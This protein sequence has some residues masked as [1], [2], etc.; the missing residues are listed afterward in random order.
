VIAVTLALCSGGI[1]VQRRTVSGQETTF[2]SPGTGESG[3]RF[4]IVGEV[5]WTPGERLAIDFGFSDAPPNGS[6]AGTFY[7]PQTVVVLRDGSWSFPV[8]VNRDLFPFPLWRPGYIVVRV[9]GA[10]QTT[11]TPFAYTVEGRQ[12]VGE[13]PLADLGDGPGADG[14]SDG[15]NTLIVAAVA[16]M[17]GA[18]LVIAG[19]RRLQLSQ[20]SSPRSRKKASLLGS[21]P[22]KSLTSTSPS[23]LPPRSR[24]VRRYW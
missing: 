2:V 9:Q 7:N 13:P 24:I 10:N 12:P 15:G 5:G 17:T 21:R 11:L 8:V 3:S 14:D 4:Q 18:V 1:L 19:N 20:T 22:R 6:Y 16:S 23:T